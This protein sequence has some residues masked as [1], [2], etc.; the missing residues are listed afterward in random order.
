MDGNEKEF[1][2]MLDLSFDGI[3]FTY[4]EIGLGNGDTLKAVDDKFKDFNAAIFGVDLP[5]WTTDRTFSKNVSLQ[6]IGSQNFFHNIHH[7]ADFIF[8]DGCHGYDCA[9]RDFLLAEKK[10]KKGGIVCLHDVDEG[11]QGLHSPQHC[12]RGIEVRKMVTDIGLLS[13][14]RKGWKILS[15]T[16]GDKTKSP[17][18]HGCLFAQWNF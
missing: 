1:E 8:I 5:S 14:K 18:G 12:G 3:Y 17:A 2:R 15:E 7:Q 4:F 10:I 9:M 6:L 16:T 13:G 11:C